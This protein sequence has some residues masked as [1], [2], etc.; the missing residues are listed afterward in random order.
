ME[1]KDFREMYYDKAKHQTFETLPDFLNEI[2]ENSFGYSSICYAVAASALAAANAANHHKKGGITGFQ[3][4]AV[5]WEFIQQW[6]YTANKCG[7]RIIDYD[8]MLY[9]QYEDNFQK[10]ISK[11]IF[12]ALQ[13]QAQILLDEHKE[14]C[15]QTEH[16]QSIVDGIIP[17]GYTIKED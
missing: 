16:W 17:F 10:T 6:N 5:M 1:E 8:N 7:L 13:K 14:G 2:F 4:G 9:A 12:E 3:A 11:S 15:L